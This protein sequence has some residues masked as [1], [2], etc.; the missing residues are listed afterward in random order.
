[1]VEMP[2]A[3]WFVVG[4][5]LIAAVVGGVLNARGPFDTH[6]ALGYDQFLADFQ[7]GKV[8]QIAQWRDQLE[9]TEQGALRSVVVPADRDLQADLGRARVAG[10]VG[11]SFV[12]VP[13]AWLGTMT[14][15]IPLLLALAAVLIWATA[16]VRSRRVASRSASAGRP[17]TAG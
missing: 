17:Q 5:L 4:F 14:P 8:E 1:V 6:P 7:A 9:V 11:I 12:G 10:G 16:I 15:W 3:R 13:D 2:R